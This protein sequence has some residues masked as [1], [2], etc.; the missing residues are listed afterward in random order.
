MQCDNEE[1]LCFVEECLI[2]EFGLEDLLFLS[3]EIFSIDLKRQLLGAIGIRKILESENSIPMQQIIETNLVPRFIELFEIDNPQLQVECALILGRLTT[4]N[5]QLIQ[6]IVDNGGITALLKLLDSKCPAI[7]EQ[8]KQIYL[9]SFLELWQ[10]K[11]NR[12]Y[13]L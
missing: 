8:V 13:L 10:K 7:T 12:L 4:G 3:K 2:K 6:R 1:L 5:S 11:K 9:Y